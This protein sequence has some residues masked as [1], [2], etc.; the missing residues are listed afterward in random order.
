MKLIK[1][2]PDMFKSGQ[3]IAQG[4]LRIWAKE[5]APKSVLAALG[6]LKNL[7]EIKAENGMVIVGHSETG[8][9]HVLERVNKKKHISESAQALIDSTNDMLCELRIQDE[10]MLTHLRPTDTHKAYLLPPGIYVQ[11]VDQENTVEGWRK[12]QD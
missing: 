4:E 11:S 5:Y 2:T 6:E 9:H 8:A 1:L 10:V 12:V 7:T 3:P